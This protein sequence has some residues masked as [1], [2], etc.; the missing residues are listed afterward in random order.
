M[1]W[2]GSVVLEF[3]IKMRCY[4]MGFYRVSESLIKFCRVLVCHS[5]GVEV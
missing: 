2:L 1:S 4:I 3:L 5:F